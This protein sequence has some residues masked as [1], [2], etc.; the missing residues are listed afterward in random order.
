MAV[1]EAIA[2]GRISRQLPSIRK[3][4]LAALHKPWQRDTARTEILRDL[5][6]AYAQ[7]GGLDE[8]RRPLLQASSNAVADIWLRNVYPDMKMT[9]GTYPD[10]SGHRGCMRCH[11]GQHLDANGEAISADCNLCHG[12]LAEKVAN[13]A[14]LQQLGIERR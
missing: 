12:V 3:L 14:I 13:P 9:W 5:E 8:A 1:D 4:A 10:F 2:A 7:N 11:D 6:Q